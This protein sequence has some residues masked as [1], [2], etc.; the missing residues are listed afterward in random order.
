[1]SGALRAGESGR[2]A[3]SGPLRLAPDVARGDTSS[4][5]VTGVP[6]FW[7]KMGDGSESFIGTTTGV[8]TN[9]WDGKL[10]VSLRL[11][12]LSS[13]NQCHGKP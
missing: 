13:F 8:L 10:T 12:W 2:R 11:G 5:D 4:E 6:Q 7:E 9:L 3:V 1:M